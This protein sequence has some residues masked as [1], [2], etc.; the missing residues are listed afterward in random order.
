MG[1]TSSS[2]CPK[3]VRKEQDQASFLE[4]SLPPNYVSSAN[5][6]PLKRKLD[7]PDEPLQRK[8]CAGAAGVLQTKSLQ[9]LARGVKRKPDFGSEGERPA[10]RSASQQNCNDSYSLVP[11][12]TYMWTLPTEMLFE[13]ALYLSGKDLRSFAQVC[14]LLGDIAGPMVMKEHGLVIPESGKFIRIQK[15]AY[16]ALMVWRRLSTFDP[17]ASWWCSFGRNC[18][19]EMERFRYFCTTINI[20]LSSHTVHLFFVANADPTSLRRVMKSI[21]NM[22]STSI[23]FFGPSSSKPSLLRITNVNPQPLSNSCLQSFRA[24]NPIFFTAALTNFTVGVLNS[25]E[26]YD[27]SLDH[28]GL[29][30]S[31]WARL[32][33]R[34]TLPRLERLSIDDSCPPLT[35]SKFLQRHPLI[36]SLY[37][38]VDSSNQPT[39]SPRIQNIRGPIKLANLVI[40]SGPSDYV[41][42]ILEHLETR[43]RLISLS[44][45]P[46]FTRPFIVDITQC[47]MACETISTLAVT[48]PDNPRVACF[49]LIG[50]EPTISH[51]KSLVVS[52]E[53][54]GTISDDASSGDNKFVRVPSI[55]YNAPD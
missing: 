50:N 37:V 39:K 3:Y 11:R 9:S 28:T 32:L 27:L 1:N 49:D 22:G 5:L 40:V 25:A 43:P 41:M 48:I 10:K 53:E 42:G 30:A 19:Q 47:A 29:K 38:R 12:S 21:T 51:V 16:D 17:R 54:N 18:D 35:L 26:I 55:F 13:I 36:E 6:L 24:C 14:R 8:R 34:A 33:P 52:N 46:T 15:K 23:Q 31:Q 4:H 45:I 2:I 20:T 44:L 7:D